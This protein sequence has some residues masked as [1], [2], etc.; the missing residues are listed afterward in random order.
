MQT[1]WFWT[2]T[3]S[4]VMTELFYR[5]AGAILAPFRYAEREVQ[6]MKEVAK[7]DMQALIGK[8][9]K[10][11]LMGLVS[12]L[13]LMFLSITVAAALNASMNSAWAGFAIVTAFY[14]LAGIGLYIWKLAV[15]KK[16]SEK[17]ERQVAQARTAAYNARTA[18]A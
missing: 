6:H 4:T 8:A 5:A 18:A 9:I 13:F 11:A 2:S 7:E 14:L 17:K 12:L 3:N 15:D 10:F 1:W 16:R